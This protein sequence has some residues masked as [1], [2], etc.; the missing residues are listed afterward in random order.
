MNPAIQTNN[1]TFAYKDKPVLDGVSLSVERGEMVGILGPNGSGKTTLLKIFSAVLKG[2][3]DVKVNDRSIETYGKRE[4]SRLFAMVPQESQI[5]FPYTVA[6]IVLMGRASYHSPLALEGKQDLE[7]ARASMEL[8]DSLS[9][10]DRY[11]HELSGG[12]KQRVIIARALA[13][14]PQILLLD[15]PSAFLDL[16]HQVQ[17]FELMRRLNREHR[18]TIVAALHDLNLAALF[19]PRLV[20]LRDGK[21]YRDGLPKEVLTEKTIEEVY[22]IRVRVEPDPS[23]RN[24]NSLSAYLHKS[25]IPTVGLLAIITFR[26]GFALAEKIPGLASAHG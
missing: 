24:R 12:E 5:L 20:M 15:E 6:E 18:L 19:F 26:T 17:V 3:G 11:L 22:G 8:T 21:V 7:V 4:L 1:L 2:R 16:K 9:F 23:G 10:S 13:Q 14:E 25:A